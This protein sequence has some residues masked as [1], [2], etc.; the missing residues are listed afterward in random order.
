MLLLLVARSV[1]RVIRQVDHRVG[2]A[3]S[4]VFHRLAHQRWQDVLVAN[5]RRETP[6]PHLQRYGADAAC[7]VRGSG[8][9]L[10]D[11]RKRGSERDVLAKRKQVDLVE[12]IAEGPI[13]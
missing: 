3:L 13:L 4:V 12:M 7:V 9:T 10:V 5:E 6:R 11:D 1:P 8:R 2:P